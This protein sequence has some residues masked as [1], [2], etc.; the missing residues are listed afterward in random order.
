MSQVEELIEESVEVEATPANVW[1]LVS[2]LPRMARWSPQVV[3]TVVLGRGPVRLGSQAVNLNR[4][5]PL[6]WP[7]RSRVV[8][9]EP[10]RDFAIRIADNRMIWSFALEPTATGTR[11]TQRREAPQGT[12]AISDRFIRL[13]MG[14][15]RSFQGELRDGM[16]ATL[17]AIKADAEA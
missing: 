1:S 16:R 15:Q 14:G 12:T 2:D 17:R 3:R 10:H 7:T 8:R 6:V 13:L 4:R 9:F 5:G 11:L